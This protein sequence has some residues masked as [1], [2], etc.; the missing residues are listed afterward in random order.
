MAVSANALCSVDV[1]AL[2]LALK[3]ADHACMRA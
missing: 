3:A 2:A 1:H